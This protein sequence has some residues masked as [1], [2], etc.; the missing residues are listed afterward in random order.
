VS[1]LDR[2][3]P[4][5]TRQEFRSAGIAARLVS[6][7]AT[8]I[9][10]SSVTSDV[11]TPAPD[12]A[13]AVAVRCVNAIAQNAASLN[14]AVTDSVTG[15]E[16]DGHPM[17]VLFN[18]RPN[19]IHSAR[20][21]K[22]VMFARMEWKGE[23]FLYLDRGET[24]QGEVQNLWPIWATVLPVVESNDKGDVL[25]GYK[26][27]TEDGRTIGLLP[28]E[29]L[30]L[31]YPHPDD[32]WGCLA[33]W[34]AASFSAGL[35]QTARAWQASELKNGG[36]PQ[37]LVYLGDNDEQQHAA[38]VAEWRSNIEGPRS[39]GRNMLVSGPLPPAVQR[40]GATAQELAYLD[41]IGVSDDDV[42]LAFGIPRDYLKGGATYENRDAAKRTLWSDKIVNTLDVVAAEADRQLLPDLGQ[43]FGF[44]VS[45]VDALSENADAITTRVVSVTST[46]LVTLDEAR[47]EL[48]L[49]PLPNGEGTMTLTAYRAAYKSGIEDQ[50]AAVSA[51]VQAGRSDLRPAGRMEPRPDA[52]EVRIPYVTREELGEPPL[53]EVRRR[54]APRSYRETQRAYAK[55]EAVGKRALAALA[56]KQA[57]VVLRNYNK[58]AGR[59]TGS[60]EIRVSGSAIFDAA[61]WE[62]E[63]R[64]ALESFLDGVYTSG[65]SSMAAAL[66]INF[67]AFDPLVSRMMEARLN[68]LAGQITETTRQILDQRLLVPG[69]E[70]GEG[71][72]DLAARITSVFTDLETWRAETIARTE[73]VGG[74]NASS[75]ESA[76]QSG[77]VTARI[78][79]AAGDDRVRDS[80]IEMD[81]YQTD[82]MDDA[83][84]NGV[85]FPGDPDGDGAETINCRCVEEYVL[86]ETSEA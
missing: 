30:W 85:M 61:Y 23:A 51:I 37:A 5:D 25:A 67:D 63:T 69:V 34:R 66:G 21:V 65:A 15:E 78:W 49:D 40:L 4:S 6:A 19:P 84:P 43:T 14:I 86:V 33:P 70:A 32:P 38:A 31:R 53:D 3:L 74:F 29:V 47:A 35:A 50:M 72:P 36:R 81:G 77:L 56:R 82:G 80:H 13:S 64:I 48:G 52:V 75:R 2:L 45:K 76:L 41:T 9:Q 10:Y 55:H 11:D 79:L 8:G 24:G 7:G 44:D 62:G 16:I 57:R 12:L 28:T 27:R 26:A 17:S 39:A 1:I 83:Y 73:T 46:D 68:A 22:E 54:R 20:F 42:M 58:Q 71:I 60:D 59:S 18:R